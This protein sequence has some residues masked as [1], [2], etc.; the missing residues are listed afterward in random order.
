MITIFSSA[1][2]YTF[3]YAN[4]PCAVL[5]VTCS[6]RYKACK[7]PSQSHNL[8]RA[9]THDQWNYKYYYE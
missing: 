3:I 4:I 2:T 6:K 1:L 8:V 7:E 5:D 9:K